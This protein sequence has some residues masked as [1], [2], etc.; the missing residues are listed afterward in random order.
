MNTSLVLFGIASF[1][2]VV[3][4]L[5]YWA[6]VF[7]VIRQRLVFRIENSLDKFKMM[8]L[9]GKIPQGGKLYG[10]IGGFL[11][12]AF[13]AANH[14]DTIFRFVPLPPDQVR[15]NKIRLQALLAEVES[16]NHQ[17]VRDI[18]DYTVQNLFV[19]YLA[20]RPFTVLAAIPLIVGSYFVHCCKSA[21]QSK[22]LDIAAS[23]WAVA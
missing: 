15:E 1:A 3:A 16:T 7:P 4:L 8:G 11:E 22:E 18:L 5:F 6:I 12:S 2:V 10:Q 20:Q 14:E 13:E 17:D 23:T 21:L 9:E 19:M